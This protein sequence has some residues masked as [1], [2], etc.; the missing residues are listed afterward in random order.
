MRALVIN[1][2]GLGD[3]ILFLPTV[4]LLKEK[5][6]GIEVDLITEPRSVSISEL[7]DLYRRVKIFNFKDKNPNILELREII[8]MHNY[9]Y[10]FC[11]GSSYK[12]NALAL[13]SSAEIKVGFYSGIFSYLLL[14]YP[15]KL[16]KKQY[17]ANMFAELLTPVVSEITTIIK[18]KDLIPEVKLNPVSIEWTKELINLRMKERYYTRKI[19]I[20]P[21]VSKLSIQKNILKGLSAGNW[22]KLI[23]KL[24]EDS[25]NTVIVVGGKDDADII[26]EIHAKLPFFAKPKN[27]FDVSKQDLDITKLAALISSC[28]LLVCLDSAPMH[29]AVA[30]G[31]KLVAFF[32][33]TD[34]E[35]LL[36]SSPKFTAVHVDNLECRPCLF[37]NRKESC[38]K[39]VCLD[40]A[41]ETILNAI[42]RL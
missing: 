27:F 9:K 16:N 42:K 8:R 6:P 41:S 15:I 29:I 20:H 2:G 33:P 40:I 1:T 4:K 19:L 7:T 35:K 21:G 36:P 22:A 14:T 31:K 39:P 13:L 12:A 34:P 18:E 10:F 30:L 23:E 24:L 5:H 37:D 11:T 38:S 3:Q 28:D 25:K 17:A 32:G 26:S